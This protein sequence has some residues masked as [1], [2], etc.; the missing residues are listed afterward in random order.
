MVATEQ[1]MLQ[2]L[3]AGTPLESITSGHGWPS[4]QVHLFAS[5]HGYLFGAD[6]IPYLPSYPRRDG[7][8]PLP[9]QRDPSAN[10]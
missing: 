1:R 7:R 2:L 8:P 10:D 4:R 3:A 9:T 5:R 6:G